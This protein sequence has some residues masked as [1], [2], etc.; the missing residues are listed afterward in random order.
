MG[1][2]GKVAGVL[3]EMRYSSLVGRWWAFYGK[4]GAAVW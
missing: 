4:C 2:G 1:N 3:Q